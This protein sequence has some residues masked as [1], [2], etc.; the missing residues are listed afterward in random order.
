MGG[1]GDTCAKSGHAVRMY[2]CTEFMKEQA[3]RNSDGDYPIVP[4]TG[5]LTIQTELGYLQG[6]P[7]Y[8]PLV[9]RGIV[10]SLVVTEASRGYILELFKGDSEV[11]AASARARRDGLLGRALYSGGE[12]G[13]D[14][15][16]ER[17]RG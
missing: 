10:F 14:L 13:G 16:G 3:M 9:P 8:I 7:K 4:Q 15:R 1:Y 11:L 12:V 2:S 6:Q 17:R 5:T